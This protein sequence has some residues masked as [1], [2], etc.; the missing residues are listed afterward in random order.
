MPYV[1]MIVDPA[2]PALRA[3]RHAGGAED[4]MAAAAAPQHDRALRGR[5]AAVPLAAGAGRRSLLAGRPLAAAAADHG[6]R[7]LAGRPQLRGHLRHRR[8]RAQPAHRLHGPGVARPRLLPRLSAPTSRRTSAASSSWPLSL[9]LPRAGVV[10]AARRRRSSGRSRCGCAATTW[11]SSR[12]AWSSSASTS[13]A[14]GRRSPA[15]TRGTSV[16]A[17]GARS[18]RSTSPTSRSFGDELHAATRASSG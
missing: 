14:T 10:G 9:W 15:A 13:S 6:R 17:A 3:V 18:G 2:H 1:V 5:P 16:D 7:L 4:L 8:H 11:R 12:S